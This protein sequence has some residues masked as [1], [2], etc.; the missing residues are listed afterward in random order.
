MERQLAI[1]TTP[2]PDT[3]EE[4]EKEL[5]RLWQNSGGSISALGPIRQHKQTST[6]GSPDSE[7]RI[8]NKGRILFGE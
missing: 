7:N 3:K 8:K 4:R 6:Q 2:A 5:K 1:A